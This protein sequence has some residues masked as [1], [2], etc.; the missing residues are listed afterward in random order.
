[1]TIMMVIIG[2]M[3]IEINFLSGNKSSKSLN[4]RRTFTNRLASIKILGLVY[5]RS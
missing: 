5:V 3:K 2:M 4:K 1:M